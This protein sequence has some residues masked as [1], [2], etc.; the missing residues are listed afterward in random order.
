MEENLQMLSLLKHIT[1]VLV[2]T[3][4]YT[5]VL[6]TGPLLKK[7]SRILDNRY[8]VLV[9]YFKYG[10]VVNIFINRTRRLQIIDTD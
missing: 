8:H 3:C 10:A 4:I 9:A 7:V 2:V 1:L 6:I 5:H